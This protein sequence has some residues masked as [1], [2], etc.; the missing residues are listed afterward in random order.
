MKWIKCISTTSHFFKNKLLYANHFQQYFIAHWIFSLH[1]DTN[2]LVISK[3]YRINYKRKS[4]IIL[5][6]CKTKSVRIMV[7]GCLYIDQ[8]CWQHFWAQC[9]PCGAHELAPF[10]NWIFSLHWDTNVLVISKV[11]RIN[12][13]DFLLMLLLRESCFGYCSIC[14]VIHCSIVGNNAKIVKV[15]LDNGADMNTKDSLGRTV[16]HYA[17]MCGNPDIIAM[18]PIIV[19]LT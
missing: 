17:Y 4:K 12:S 7:C 14:I 5:Y 1:W 10:S 9:H 15:L 13:Y 6:Y 16:F 18:L 8:L 3:V 19:I 2:V 11:Y